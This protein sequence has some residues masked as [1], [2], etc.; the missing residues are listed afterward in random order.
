M[1]DV[2]LPGFDISVGNARANK[3]LLNTE[4]EKGERKAAGVVRLEARLVIH[5]G[6]QFPVTNN[7]F[8]SASKDAPPLH[9]H[10]SVYSSSFIP[11]LFT[12]KKLPHSPSS[13]LLKV[14]VSS[15]SYTPSPFLPPP[16]PQPIRVS[17]SRTIKICRNSR[18][19]NG[20][21]FLYYCVVFILCNARNTTF[22][23]Q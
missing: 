20:T 5:S 21:S 22:I 4:K 16:H 14:Q 19:C 15:S 13:I 23:A 17:Q 18:L 11:S 3:N 1:T 12:H 7:G 10:P 6:E 2:I 8:L 9:T